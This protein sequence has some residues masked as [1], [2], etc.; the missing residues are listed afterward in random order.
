MAVLNNSNLQHYLELWVEKCAVALESPQG[1]SERL[2][3]IKEFCRGFVPLDI[4]TDDMEAYASE[5]AADEVLNN[6]I[7]DRYCPK[8]YYLGILQFDL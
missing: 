8:L 3:A 2:E 5:L 1:S 7:D 4:S 6:A